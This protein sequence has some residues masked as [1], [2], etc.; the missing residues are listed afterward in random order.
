MIENILNVREKLK[1]LSSEEQKRL[2]DEFRSFLIESPKDFNHLYKALES[3]PAEPIREP[4]HFDEQTSL[5]LNRVSSEL[6][7][8]GI[9]VWPNFYSDEKIIDLKKVTLTCLNA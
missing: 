1:E 6:K 8:V 2:L 3:I 4:Y 9:S 5:E 7:D